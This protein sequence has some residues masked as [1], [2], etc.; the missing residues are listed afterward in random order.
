MQVNY[1]LHIAGIAPNLYIHTGARKTVDGI[2]GLIAQVISMG[3]QLACYEIAED[4]LRSLSPR[5]LRYEQI[6][7]KP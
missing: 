6:E 5:C 1:L 7:Q 3:N 4:R 2:S